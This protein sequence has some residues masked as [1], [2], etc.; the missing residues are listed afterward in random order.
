[1]IVTDI[2]SLRIKSNN[3]IYKELNELIHSLQ[4]KEYSAESKLRDIR[5]EIRLVEY[6]L[7][8]LELN[9]I[10]SIRKEK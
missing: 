1:M 9:I 2:L 8:Q 5:E 7:Q 6:K 3:K 4:S 10:D